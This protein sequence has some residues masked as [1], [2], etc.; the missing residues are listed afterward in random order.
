MSC[1]APWRQQLRAARFRNAEFYVKSAE[2]QAGRRVALHEYPK[3]DEAWPEDMGQKADQFRIEALVIGPEYFKARDTLINALKQ[4]GPGTLIHPYYGSRTVTLQSP[5]R[6]SE[7]PEQGGMARFSL[8]FVE[9]GEN[10]EPLARADTQGALW[11]AA[12]DARTAVSGD[13]AARFSVSGTPAF[14]ETAAAERARAVM[15]CLSTLS[16]GLAS[17]GAALSDQA[18]AV[19]MALNEMNR[20]VRQPAALAQTVLGLIDGIRTLAARPETALSAYR[21]LFNA[22]AKDPR[23]APLTPARR[24]CADNQG[25]LAALTRRG[26]LISSAHAASQMNIATHE[27]AVA[28]RDELATRIEDEAAGIVPE[29]TAILAV[30][31][32][33]YQALTALRAA[34]VRDFSARAIDAPRL[35]RV[36]LPSTLPALVAAYRIHG[37]ATLAEDLIARNPRAIR[38]PGFVP[39]GVALA[40]RGQG[41]GDRRQ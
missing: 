8:D 15:G 13:F 20:L 24:R 39:G 27:Q 18:A 41:T 9:A 5:A 4:R 1:L 12:D 17:G 36:T 34:L 40:F 10:V 32:P 7:S 6:I 21:G 25:A 11:R 31:D 16:R 14:V 28:V 30:A 35:K 2:T 19:S 38:H 37:D 23:I 22:G 33:V 3:R 29:A 26:A